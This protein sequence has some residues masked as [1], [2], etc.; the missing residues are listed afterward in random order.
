MTKGLQI[1][2]KKKYFP[3]KRFLKSRT[4]TENKYK[5]YKNKLTGII[6]KCKQNYYNKILEN[7]RNNAKDLWKILNNVRNM[8]R[9]IIIHTSLK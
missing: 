3:F 4:K 2:F 7:N 1:A 5:K 8:L 9:K 6:R